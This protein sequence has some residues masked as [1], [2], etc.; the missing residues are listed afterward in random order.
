MAFCGNCGNE[1]PEGMKFCPNCGTAVVVVNNTT[2][3]NSDNGVYQRR[4]ASANST[5]I[6]EISA[7]ERPSEQVSGIDKV[8]K[9]FGIGLLILAIIC[10]FSDPAIVTILLSG[11]IIVGTA[12]CLNKKY[13]LKAFTI[14]ALILAVICLLCGIWQAKQIGLFKVPKDSGYSSTTQVAQDNGRTDMKETKPSSSSM[15]NG[16]TSSSSE[17][18]APAEEEQEKTD[19]VST[20]GV[21]P[22]LKAFLD[23]YEEFMD[24]YIE[25]MQKYMANPTDLNL[26]GEYADIMAKYQDFET[27]INKYDSKQMSSA[28]AAY[29]LEVTT[30]VTQKMMKIYSN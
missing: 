16:I 19:I 28:D 9:F 15:S 17:K 5:R 11:V 6:M 1:V 3:D 12:F 13:K 20:G 29:Y 22:D 14:I 26:L 18:S 23:S 10:F 24:E 30:R 8:G 21:D 25:F 27:K 7:G 4:P 2:D